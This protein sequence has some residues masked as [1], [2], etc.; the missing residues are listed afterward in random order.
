MAKRQLL[1]AWMETHNVRTLQFDFRDEPIDFFAGQFITVSQQFRGY[2]RPVKRAYSIASSPL[3]KGLVEVTI[4]REVPGLMS[5]FLTEMPVGQELEVIGPAGKYLY[6]PSRGRKLLLLGAG[7]GITP[8]H[9]MTRFVLDSEQP[10]S[11]VRLF[12]SVRTPRDIIYDKLWDKLDADH[13]NFHYNLTMT[14]TKPEDWAGR[15]GRITKEWVLETSGDVSDHVAYI[16]GPGPF[17]E[18]MEQLSK[19]LGIEPDRI[20][21]E[22]W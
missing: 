18:S 11:T 16:C 8:L 13:D 2:K 5:Q 20:N 22:K 1:N 4:K 3:Q 15:H 17:V 21:V 7:S 19:D 6:E 12:F 14:R 10:D 9:S